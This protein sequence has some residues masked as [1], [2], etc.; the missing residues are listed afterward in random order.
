MSACLDRPHLIFVCLQITGCSWFLVAPTCGTL[1]L[2]ILLYAKV[3]AQRLTGKVIRLKLTQTN[4]KSVITC[5]LVIPTMY[6]HLFTSS[7][8]QNNE[9]VSLT[10]RLNFDPSLAISTREVSEKWPF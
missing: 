1:L 6:R 3:A 9:I 7:V 2:L 5:W 10:L 8:L 4:I